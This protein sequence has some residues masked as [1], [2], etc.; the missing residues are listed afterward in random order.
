[1]CI[2]AHRF[3]STLYIPMY[4]ICYI[5]L[6][7]YNTVGKARLLRSIINFN[8]MLNDRDILCTYTIFYSEASGS[9]PRSRR[10]RGITNF[11]PRWKLSLFYYFSF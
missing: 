3:I 1:M 5:I 8:E 7:Y 11:P 9:Q 4:M 2:Y 6:Y 10:K